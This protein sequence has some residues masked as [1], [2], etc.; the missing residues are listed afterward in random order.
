M[1]AMGDL[2]IRGRVW[3]FS[4]KPGRVAE[5]NKVEVKEGFRMRK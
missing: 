1:N 4:W 3:N 5:V 2:M